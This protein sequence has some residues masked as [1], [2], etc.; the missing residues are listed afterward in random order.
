MIL[1][2]PK[3]NKKITYTQQLSKI[4]NTT[5]IFIFYHPVFAPRQV[6]ILTLDIGYILY[7]LRMPKKT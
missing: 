6:A 2:R 1:F 7:H 4:N 3:Y 5:Y